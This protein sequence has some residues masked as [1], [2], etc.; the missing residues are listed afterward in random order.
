MPSV[1]ASDEKRTTPRVLPPPCIRYISLASPLPYSIADDLTRP[2]PVFVLL[3]GSGH[4]EDMLWRPMTGLM[5]AQEKVAEMV[6]IL[7]PS[8]VRP[9]EELVVIEAED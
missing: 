1:E 4:V 6:W 5:A 7:S 9:F 2:G 3:V 8:R